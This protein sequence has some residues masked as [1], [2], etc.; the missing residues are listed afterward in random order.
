MAS[1]PVRRSDPMVKRLLAATF[2]NYKGRKVSVAAWSGPL[3][4][5]LNWSGGTR[6]EVVLVDVTNGRI[7]RLVVPSP[8]AAGAHD[9]VGTPPGS[10]LAVHSYFMGRDV[11][12]TFYVRPPDAGAMPAGG[13]AALLGPG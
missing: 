8:W 3:Y 4:L 12:V 2:P 6:D 10:I 11:G 13:L 7:G 5:D 9:P 1:T